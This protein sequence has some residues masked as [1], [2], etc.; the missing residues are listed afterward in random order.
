MNPTNTFRAA[1]LAVTLLSVTAAT[2]AEPLQTVRIGYPPAW[3][4]VEA[5]IPFGD[6]L[7]FFKD[8]GI[9]LEYVSVQG[10][11]V[12]LPQVASGSVEFGIMTP[13][14]AIIAASKGEPFPVKFF[15][16]FYPRNIFEFTV[17][18]D[19]PIKTLADLKGKKLG[20]GALSWGNLPMS[21]LMLQDVGVTWMK[22]IQV[23]PVGVGPA[24]WE[25][26]KSGSVDALNLPATQ[27]V[28]M[29]QGG[30]PIRRLEIPE[31]F[32][33]VFSNGIATSDELIQKK[34]ELV[35]GM[36]R[37]VAKSMVAC[38]ANTENCVRAYW[39]IDPSSKPAPDGQAQW[40]RTFVAVNQG[41]YKI[42]D[43]ASSAGKYGVYTDSDWKNIIQKMK[44]GEQ[45]NSVDFDTSQLYTD[46]FTKSFNN[47]DANAVRSA[48]NA[49]Q[50]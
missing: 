4:A 41:T 19:S 16:N 7:G 17:L 22:D 35:E 14:L 11:A 9:A 31:A 24:A 42:G 29:E 34:P 15:Y 25:R 21:R 27:N 3:S 8:E 12:L 5:A 1:A 49:A 23:M 10:T 45:I 50:P 33:K 47:F 6:T 20:V 26:L 32:R 40:I 39:K 18:K 2:Q 30:T 13:D 28:M 46:R 38:M 44:D 37:A 36:G 43:M 48:A